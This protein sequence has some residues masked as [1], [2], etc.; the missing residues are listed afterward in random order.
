MKLILE[1]N[2]MTKNKSH[3][4]GVRGLKCFVLVC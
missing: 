1:G 2:I 3:P 4:T